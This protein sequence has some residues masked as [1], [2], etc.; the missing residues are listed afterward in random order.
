MNN[1]A[2]IYLLKTKSGNTRAICEAC[3]KLLIRKPEQCLAGIFKFHTLILPFH[4]CLWRC[5]CRLRTLTEN[6]TLPL[7]SST[8]LTHIQVGKLSNSR[9][10]YFNVESIWF[11]MI[12]QG[13]IPLI[14]LEINDFISWNSIQS[15]P[16]QMIDEYLL[17]Y[18]HLLLS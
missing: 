9:V 7:T 2:S 15:L 16:K 10:K 13:E 18:W 14:S 4:G 6:S 11:R 5:K 3:L 12:F 8:F 17:Y 1:P